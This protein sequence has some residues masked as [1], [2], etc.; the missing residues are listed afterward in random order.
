MNFIGEYYVTKQSS[1]DVIVSHNWILRGLYLDMEMPILSKDFVIFSVF[2]LGERINII[3]MLYV[4]SIFKQK[5]ADC[6]SMD[7]LIHFREI[8]ANSCGYAMTI[9]LWLKLSV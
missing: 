6:F 5:N 8:A 7:F 3:S 4:L 1:K 2:N 9:Y